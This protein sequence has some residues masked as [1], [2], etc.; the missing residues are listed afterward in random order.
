MVQLRV[1]K[2]HCRTIVTAIVTP[3]IISCYNCFY[4]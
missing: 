1:G 3:V 2:E 4:C